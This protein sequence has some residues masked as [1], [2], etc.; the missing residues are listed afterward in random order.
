[1]TTMGS[2]PGG[3]ICM[4]NMETLEERREAAQEELQFCLTEGG[5]ISLHVL[6]GVR[7]R[8]F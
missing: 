7:E 4:V 5:Q 6:W 1:M 3:N 2:A 8:W